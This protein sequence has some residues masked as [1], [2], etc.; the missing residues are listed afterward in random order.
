MIVHYSFR[1]KCGGSTDSENKGEQ[2]KGVRYLHQ[3]MSDLRGQVVDDGRTNLHVRPPH[4]SLNLRCGDTKLSTLDTQLIL[5]HLSAPSK[6]RS[7]LVETHQSYLEDDQV[8][9]P[10][11]A[12]LPHKK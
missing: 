5:I 4:L 6:S 10:F 11:H 2:A 12:S 7:I 1:I 3:R 8:V 9:L